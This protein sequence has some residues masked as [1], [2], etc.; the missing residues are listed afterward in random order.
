MYNQK[1]INTKRPSR[2]Y[3]FFNLT[4]CI[5][6]IIVKS[7]ILKQWHLIITPNNDCLKS[8]PP[9]LLNVSP[10]WLLKFSSCPASYLADDTK[11]IFP[12]DPRWGRT[13][14]QC[15][16]ISVNYFW[17]LLTFRKTFVRLISFPEILV[18][19]IFWVLFCNFALSPLVQN[20]SV[21]NKEI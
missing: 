7:M 5:W 2:L 11:I 14:W 15:T 8:S 4:Y 18:G 17:P 6:C 20:K 12:P 9:P 10:P 16:L 13:L 3:S 1:D 19:A 21:L